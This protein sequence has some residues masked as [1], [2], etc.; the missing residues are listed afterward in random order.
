[1]KDRNTYFISPMIKDN[2]AGVL[3]SNQEK[4]RSRGETIVDI[5]YQ[6]VRGYTMNGEA[7]LLSAIIITEA[8]DE[9]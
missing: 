1:M 7:I 5:K 4:I 3:A 2:F 8:L 6:A 9:V